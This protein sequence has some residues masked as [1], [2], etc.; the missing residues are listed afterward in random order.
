MENK[1]QAGKFPVRCHSSVTPSRNVSL[2]P[3]PSATGSGDSWGRP[4]RLP[5]SGDRLGGRLGGR[6]GKTAG[7]TPAGRTQAGR[8]RHPAYFP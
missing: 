4:S 6:V 1:P 3:R 8:L 7:E 2:V 5:P